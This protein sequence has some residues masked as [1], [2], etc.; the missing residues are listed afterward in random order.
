MT[1]YWMLFLSAS[2]LAVIASNRVF[3]I[4]NTAQFYRINSLWWVIIAVLSVIIGLRHEVGGDWS[5]YL[6]IFTLIDSDEFS[7]SSI[8][9]MM[10]PVSM[11]AD[12]STP[13]LFITIQA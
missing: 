5:G 8:S 6:K 4:N 7:T 12:T 2:F 10:D 11:V 3:T 1:T 13:Y 9:V